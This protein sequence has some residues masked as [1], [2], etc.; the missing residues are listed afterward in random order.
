MFNLIVKLLLD[1]DM[2]VQSWNNQW[3]LYFS[4]N[5]KHVD[6]SKQYSSPS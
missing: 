5:Q 4:N 2:S 3:S 1:F 6:F